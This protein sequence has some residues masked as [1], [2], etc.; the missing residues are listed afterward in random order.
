MD[1]VILVVVVV[2]GLVFSYTNGF[3][4]AASAVA[5][6][7][8]TRALPPRA[9]L[10][11][12]AAGNLAGALLSAGVAVTV[13]KGIIAPPGGD[14]GMAVLFA[15]LT[16]AILWNLMTWYFAVPSSS[17][18]SL[19]GGMVGAGLASGI[20]VYWRSG[21]VDA[22][23]LPMVISP[24]IGFGG[25]YLLMI[26]AL[27]IFRRAN[28]HRTERG[29]R[30]A[31]IFSAASLAVGHGLQDAQ[32]SMGIIVLALVTADRRHGFE[33]PLWVVLVCAAAMAAGTFSGGWRIMRT[34]GRRIFPLRP[35][36]GFIAEATSSIVLYLTAYFIAAPISTTQVITSS[37][38][39]VGSTRR[40]SAVRWSVAREIVI[41]WVLTLPA[42]AAVAAAVYALTA[43]ISPG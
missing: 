35:Q 41:A 31:Q 2:L 18:Q 24:L 30:I 36:H 10:A 15:A 6:A 3:H 32:K 26:A 1:T 7:I 16:G 38:M 11:L 14:K 33:V 27:W 21:V 13:A 5:S 43:L 37:V 22:V 28:P 23:L 29:F 17:S 34:L 40:F 25:G 20:T 4:D 9:A 12:A 42:A 19:I 39:G 8:S